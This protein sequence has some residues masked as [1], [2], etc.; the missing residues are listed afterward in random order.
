MNLPDACDTSIRPAT[1]GGGGDVPIDGAAS[2]HDLSVRWG[3]EHGAAMSVGRVRKNIH[4]DALPCATPDALVPERFQDSLAE[5]VGIISGL[6]V[7][8]PDAEPVW[9]PV[10][11]DD[12]WHIINRL[13]VGMLIS[14]PRWKPA[15]RWLAK[16]RP[17]KP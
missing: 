8:R 5:A 2:S 9:G 6:L 14:D 12:A 7:D 13:L 17:I 1:M 11:C 3:D 4:A 16:N 10:S 15:A